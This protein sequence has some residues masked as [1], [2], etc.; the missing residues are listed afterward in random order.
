MFK[1][2][3]YVRLNE[4]FCREE[5]RKLIYMITDVNNATKRCYIAALNTNLS[6]LPQELV[7]F[8]M[9]RKV[10]EK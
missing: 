3:D 9:I 2:G 5:E 6:I 7:S 8:E 4:E 10:D 1:V